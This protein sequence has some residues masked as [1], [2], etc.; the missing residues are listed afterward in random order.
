[1]AD[2]RQ[3]SLL[4][5]AELCMERQRGFVRRIDCADHC[6]QPALAGGVDQGAEE[7]AS[8]A[9]SLRFGGDVHGMFDRFGKTGKVAKR[10][11]ASVPKDDFIRS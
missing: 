4:L 7:G 3:P 2:A 5:E 10:A 9:L 11:E 1:M 6:G 8:H